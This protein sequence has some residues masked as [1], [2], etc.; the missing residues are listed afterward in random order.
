MYYTIFPSLILYI[1]A[2][3]ITILVFITYVHNI[4]VEFKNK[5]TPYYNIILTVV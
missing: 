1:I 2:E 3:P 4:I 5:L